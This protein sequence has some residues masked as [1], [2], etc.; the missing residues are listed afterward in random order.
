MTTSI[1]PIIFFCF[2]RFIG[3]NN[4]LNIVNTYRNTGSL[5]ITGQYINLYMNEYEWDDLWRRRMFY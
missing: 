1:I 2:D 4:I 5:K 3:F